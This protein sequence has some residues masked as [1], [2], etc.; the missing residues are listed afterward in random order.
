MTKKLV[1]VSLGLGFALLASACM[2]GIIAI[3]EYQISLGK[4]TA[5]LVFAGSFLSLFMLG[6]LAVYVMVAVTFWED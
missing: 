5:E 6:F 2:S 1:G 4:G 3:M